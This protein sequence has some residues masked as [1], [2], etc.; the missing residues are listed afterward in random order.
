MNVTILFL[1]DVVLQ[2]IAGILLWFVAFNFIEKLK[3][4]F[5]A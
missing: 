1:A 2:L 3:Y 5:R 4:Q